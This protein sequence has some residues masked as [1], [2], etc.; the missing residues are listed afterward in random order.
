[1]FSKK[2]FLVGVN[3]KDLEDIFH[4][5]TYEKNISSIV[6]DYKYNMEICD[7]YKNTIM[8][9]LSNSNLTPGLIDDLYYKR[10]DPKSQDSKK[11]WVTIS[12]RVD[13]CSNF[14]DEYYEYIDWDIF[15]FYNAYI[16]RK[17][18]K[19]ISKCYRKIIIIESDY[20]NLTNDRDPTKK[21]IIKKFNN[22]SEEVLTI[23]TNKY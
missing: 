11:Y 21:T 6:A 1:M 17:Y 23:K 5:R 18:I 4:E 20:D 16:E 13:L 19:Y 15:F 14:L 2:T 7:Y 8:E 3:E 22:D 12:K 9:S 10:L